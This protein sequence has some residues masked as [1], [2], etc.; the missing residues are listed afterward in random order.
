MFLV[1]ALFVVCVVYWLSA[2]VAE[3]A[4]TSEAE[5]SLPPPVRAGFGFLLTV[6]YISA[7]WQFMAIQQAW[8]LGAALLLAYLLGKPEASSVASARAAGRR[9]LAEHARP[10]A[11]ILAAALV[12]FEPLLLSRNFGPFTEGG[13]DISIY[14]DT[15]KFLA[16][17]QLT[18]FGRPSAGLDDVGRNV[19]ETLVEGGGLRRVGNINLMNPPATE[20]PAYRI[21]AFRT[22]SPFLYAP[23]AAYGFLSGMTNYHVY[24]G[25]Q[26]FVYGCLLAGVWAFFRRFGLPIAIV[27]LLLAGG[28]HSVVSVFYNT[29]SAHAIAL[30]ILALLLPALPTVP[31][32]SRAG[33]RTYGSALMIVWITYIH[34]LA[35]LLPMLSVPV[36][37][38]IAGLVRRKGGPP[39]AAAPPASHDSRRLLR[40]V[41]VAILLV[42]CAALAWA[43]SFK[44]IEFAKGL[45]RS[46]YT[47]K[48]MGEP[49][50]A[51]GDHWLSF[52]FGFM[53]QQHYHPF[54]MEIATLNTLI[55][56]GV[57]AGIAALAL[58]MVAMA[59]VAASPRRPDLDARFYLA[60]YLI[61]IVTAA[62]H[63]YMVRGTLY[64]QAKGAQNVL[65]CVYVVMLLPLALI[66]RGAGEGRWIRV[67]KYLTGAALAV[68]CLTLLLPR[69]VNAVRLALGFDRASILEPSYFSEAK[70]IRELDANPLVLI[71]PR[72]SGDL[73]IS[74]QP[75]FGARSVPTQHLILQ[76]VEQSTPE[77]AYEVNRVSALELLKPADLPHTW[78]LRWQRERRWAA[79]ERVP[80]LNVRAPIYRYTWTAE[81]LADRR[82]PALLISSGMYER[83]FS[84]RVLGG[85]VSPFA[86]LAAP[87]S[88]RKGMFSYV[89]NGMVVLY[90][91]GGGAKA[92]V[93]VEMQPRPEEAYRDL[94]TDVGGRM[95]RGEFGRDVRIEQ[96]GRVV[97]LRYEFAAENQPSVHTVA[98]SQNEYFVNVRV[99][100]KDVR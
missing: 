28:S 27:S 83:N 14:A 39:R 97:R 48:Y 20:Y 7:A 78:V 8:A 69:G 74:D 63:F 4:M 19:E 59:T 34:Y 35:I 29:Y 36:L 31:F 5:R 11:A 26:A 60:I 55:A 95:S 77:G 9:F 80:F 24:Y 46:A 100:G 64:T 50:A 70:R 79:I 58:G 17:R 43:G 56:I 89:N 10:F 62:I 23:Y 96:T 12:F 91:P 98:R 18:E 30:A 99:N 81:R 47:T 15:A 22:M 75:F 33:L 13:G 45:L 37:W 76:A 2:F 44:S 68:F 88:E 57:W 51:F 85:P 90:L 72:N 40:G 65:L 73:Y 41:P 67:L 38:Q 93:E 82:D 1:L 16:D 42:L 61:A 66:H 49:V 86:Q 53:S 32:F 21:L 94:A 87:E 84:D 25:V 71:E 3:I 54:M 52:L 92:E 6:V